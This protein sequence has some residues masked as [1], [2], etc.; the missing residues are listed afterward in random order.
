MFIA[1]DT[2]NGVLY[3]KICTS[4]RTGNSVTKSYINLGRVLD[5][6]K[7]VYQNRERGVFTYDPESN[8]YGKPEVS[9]LPDVQDRRR[10]MKLV[11][12]FG[13]SFLL[14]AFVKQSGLTSAIDA[15]GYGNP[16]TLYAMIYYYVLCR[17]SNCHA[18]DWWEGNYVRVICPDANL[19][20][21]RISDFLASVG[22]E[23]SQ[24]DFFREYLKLLTQ[25]QTDGTNVLI[26]STGLPNSIHFPLTAISKHNGD[27][28]EEVRLI[29]VTQQETGLPL[30]F[31][32]CPGN[33]I[34]TSTLTRTI[35]ELKASGVNTKFAIFDAGYSDGK[36]LRA[37]YECEVSFITRLKENAVV[38]KKL[39]L[40]N[41]KGIDDE[42]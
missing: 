39:V 42:E 19:S 38:Y 37:L 26:D 28:E 15:I 17:M 30:Y 4:K 5:K 20:S 32:Y 25:E 41:M 40:E 33:V 3:A 18:Q 12:D 14:D 11:L 27:I 24:R 9:F 21:Q 31:R 2:K 1:Y 36:N 29:Y 6:E 10:R 13:D 34:D 8:E 23:S 35:A 16:D 22:D 7:G